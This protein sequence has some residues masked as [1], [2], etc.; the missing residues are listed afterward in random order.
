MFKGIAM[1]RWRS[2]GRSDYKRQP[3][4]RWDESAKRS[5]KEKNTGSGKKGNTN[6]TVANTN[7]HALFG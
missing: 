2:G 1:P 4:S 3:K 6:N 7:Y 5:E